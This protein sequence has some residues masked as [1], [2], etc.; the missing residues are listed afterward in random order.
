MLVGTFRVNKLL[1]EFGEYKPCGD[2]MLCATTLGEL[3]LLG[4]AASL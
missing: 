4:T 1:S 3:P 2:G